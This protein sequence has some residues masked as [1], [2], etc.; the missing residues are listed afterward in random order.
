MS[1]SQAPS[2]VGEILLL[3]GVM[4]TAAIVLGLLGGVVINTFVQDKEERPIIY[5]VMLPVVVV[6][7][8]VVFLGLS[9]LK[10]KIQGKPLYVD[11]DQE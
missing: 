8:F 9:D 6:I 5:C 4:L 11:P 7:I 3:A 1:K 10:N 2:T